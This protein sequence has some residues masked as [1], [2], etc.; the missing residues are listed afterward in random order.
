MAFQKGKVKKRK[1]IQ[2]FKMLQN[3][4]TRCDILLIIS[5]SDTSTETGFFKNSRIL[6]AEIPSIDTL[7]ALILLKNP[8]SNR[9][10]KTTD[11]GGGHFRGVSASIG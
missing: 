6:C 9:N 10:Q 11:T 4:A 1:P 8:V 2:F 7:F 3:S 5:L